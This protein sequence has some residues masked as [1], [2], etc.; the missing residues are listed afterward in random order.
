MLGVHLQSRGILRIQK[1][2]E[3]CARD[4]LIFVIVP[5]VALVEQWGR[6]VKEQLPAI[7]VK[8]LVGSDDIDRWRE[9]WIWDSVFESSRIIICTYQV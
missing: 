8:T 1:E 6:V 4:Q 3:R 2:V 5:A 9:Q 7:P